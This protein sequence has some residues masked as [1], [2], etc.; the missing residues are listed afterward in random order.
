[1]LFTAEIEHKSI[2][3]TLLFV[4]LQ[5]S[6]GDGEKIAIIGRNGVGKTTLF[7][8]LTGEDTDYTGHITIRRSAVIVATAQEHHDV[9]DTSVVQYILDNLPE[10]ARLK[11]VIDTAPETM[12]E[13]MKK[14]ERYSE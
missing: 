12:G 11:H 3:N 14:I 9:G 10:Y 4:D 5:V 7:R 13:D 6:V 8:M 1:M 2:G